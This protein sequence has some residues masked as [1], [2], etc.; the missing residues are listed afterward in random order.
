MAIDFSYSPQQAS[1]SEVDFS[2]SPEEAKPKKQNKGLVAD[3]GT[4]LKRGVQNIPS[5][6]TGL[7]DIPVA[8]VTGSPLISAAAEGLGKMT[9]FQPGQWAKD[10][11]QEYSE[12]RKQARQNIDAAWKDGTA[13]DI[14]SAYLQN[15]SQIVGSIAESLPSMLVGGLAGRAAL[16]IG[17]RAVSAGAGGVGPALPGAIA[18]TVGEKLAPAVGAGL[19]EG[20]VMAGQ[21]M[22]NLTEQGVDPR[23]AA[24]YAA[25]TGLVG[26]AL[27]AGGGKVAQM[28]GVV[29]P[30]TAIAGGAARAIREGA[31][32]TK[33][34]AAK[35]TGKNIIG[36][37]ISEGIFE[38]LPQSVM[39]QAF[40]NL[41]QDKPIGE[42]VARAG[43]EGALAGFGMGAGFNAIPAKQQGPLSR[44]VDAG[45][46]SGAIQDQPPLALGYNANVRTDGAPLYTYPDGSTLTQAEYEQRQA[47]EEKQRLDGMIQDAPLTRMAERAQERAAETAPDRDLANL[48][49]EEKNR[50][51][52]IRSGLASVAL[53]RQQA[54]QEKQ[55]ARSQQGDGSFSTMN[56][57]ADLLNSERQ[58][59]E[60]S[61]R[62][63]AAK[64][65]LRRESDLESADARVADSMAKES[66][67]KRRSVLE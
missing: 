23:T 4:D 59:V 30:E 13:G 6:I 66:E 63:I 42:G 26:A 12:G 56:E 46:Q 53:E 44:T 67:Q 1:D 45:R 19:G 41:A 47:A 57:F 24:G 8:A 55:A 35:E 21:A 51:D 2:Y 37:G 50:L 5:A 43:V 16:G 15:P 29:D 33:W 10:A 9:G 28:L 39:E 14:A 40:S 49:A 52:P 18:R 22:D 25:G 60:S 62:A 11:E 64:Q 58:Q 48:I 54:R 3:I 36:G 27:G 7:A 31:N 65:A 34:Q 38:E 17:G 32:A 61:R 20:A